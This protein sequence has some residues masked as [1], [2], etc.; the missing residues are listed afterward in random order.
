M[1]AIE[2]ELF[3]EEVAFGVDGGGE[4]LVVADGAA[5]RLLEIDEDDAFEEALDTTAA[6]AE[7]ESDGQSTASFSTATSMP[8]R[9]KQVSKKKVKTE[10]W[11][12]LADEEELEVFWSEAFMSEVQ[13]RFDEM[14]QSLRNQL[15]NI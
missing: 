5:G 10:S 8:E 13:K 12:D 1:G 11:E 7:E 3:G 14:H 9:P 2:T 6:A 15:E 4:G